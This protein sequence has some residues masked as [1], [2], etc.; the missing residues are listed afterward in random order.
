MFKY[1]TFTRKHT[2]VTLVEGRGLNKTHWFVHDI[3]PLAALSLN[4]TLTVRGMILSR[5]M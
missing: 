2:V 4:E 3:V 1:A 5:W